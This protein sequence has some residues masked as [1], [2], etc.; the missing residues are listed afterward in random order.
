MKRCQDCGN[1]LTRTEHHYYE[2]RC[3]K[4]ERAFHERL[5]A[6]R[7]GAED[8]ELDKLFSVPRELH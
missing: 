3:E 8:E 1:R 6:W 2:Y 4:C 5:E 7:H